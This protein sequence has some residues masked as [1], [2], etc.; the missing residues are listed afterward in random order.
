MST[1]TTNEHDNEFIS[2]Q[3]LKH[4]G[5]KSYRKIA[6]ATGHNAETIR[7]YISDS[8]K[9]SA[10]FVKQ[11]ST[12]FDIDANILLHGHPSLAERKD[13]RFL[14]TESLLLELAAR[15]GRIE[16]TLVGMTLHSENKS[17]GTSSVLFR[18][19]S[20]SY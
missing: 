14:S 18:K 3:L 5:D 9:I 7:R 17:N 2:Q 11:V 16:D 4:L 8:S 10:S 15:F 1:K 19:T 6:A 20:M 13:L 12:S